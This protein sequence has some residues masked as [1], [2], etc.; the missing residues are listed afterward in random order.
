MKGS[1]E[2]A[3]RQRSKVHTQHTHT[4]KKLRESIQRQ[5]REKFAF[6]VVVVVATPAITYDY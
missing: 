6:V 3:R 1:K 2:D 5:K 4:G